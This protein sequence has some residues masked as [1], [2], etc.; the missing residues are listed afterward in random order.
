MKMKYLAS[1]VASVVLVT[2]HIPTTQA[3]QIV[4]L[5]EVGQPRELTSTEL[6][7][8]KEQREENKVVRDSLKVQR[9]SLKEVKKSAKGGS[10]PILSDSGPLLYCDSMTFD[11]GVVS[12]KKG[13]ITHTFVIENC[14]DAPLVITRVERSCS[15]MKAQ[16][17]K[18][19]IAVGERRIL[20]VTYEVMKMPPGL[21]SKVVQIYS[22]SRDM[23]FAQF[24][25]TG[26][27]V[28][29]RRNY[30]EEK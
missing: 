20:K 15:C 29:V 13:E 14:G 7:R 17:S 30:E 25:I 8:S 16:I 18:R 4:E 5:G 10:D 27:S 19:P 12:R 3:E 11:F 22:N 28:S 24:T 26:R 2:L 1:V 23:G 6:L 9:D 21:F